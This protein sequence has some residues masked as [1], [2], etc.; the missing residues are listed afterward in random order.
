MSLRRL[1]MSYGL[2][3]HVLGWLQSYLGNHMQYVR[4]GTASS[5]VTFLLCGVPQGSVL[6]PILF[7]LY[8]EDLLGLAEKHQLRPHLYADD[9]QIYGSCHPS[10]ASQLQQ[11]L[12][13]C[14]DEVT[15]WM[16]SNWLPLN[17]S[18]TQV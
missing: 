10:A 14:V 8:T 12:S 17:A 3:S 2:R 5:T 9:T 11:W 15:L 7:V 6:G 13:V 1:E 18:K 4:R 16:Q